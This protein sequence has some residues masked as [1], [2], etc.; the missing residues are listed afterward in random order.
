[1]SLDKNQWLALVKVFINHLIVRKGG[2]LTLGGG[3]LIS[4]ELFLPLSCLLICLLLCGLFCG[5]FFSIS[6][7]IKCRI[8]GWWVGG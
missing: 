7:T 2:N 5:L 6:E 3:D 4:P 1:M 8:V